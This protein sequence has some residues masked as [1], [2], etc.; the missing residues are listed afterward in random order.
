MSSEVCS[1][2]RED[3]SHEGVSEEES[4]SEESASVNVAPSASKDES[5]EENS[6]KESRPTKKAKASYRAKAES[7]PIDFIDCETTQ[8]DLDSLRVLYSILDD[9]DLRL[10]GK[11]NTPSRLTKGYVTL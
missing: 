1:S 9:I 10:P 3:R 2:F 8:E 4:S 7:Y 5:K 11:V 6:P